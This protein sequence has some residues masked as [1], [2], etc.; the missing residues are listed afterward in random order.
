MHIKKSY[1]VR[2][3]LTIL[4]IFLA[5]NTYSLCSIDP[6][7]HEPVKGDPKGQWII[8]EEN[9]SL[10][11]TDEAYTQ[12][13][14]VSFAYDIECESRWI[15]SIGKNIRESKFG[16]LINI[17]D[18]RKFEMRSTLGLG[19]H[20]FSPIDISV[21]ELIPN[22][23]PY[24]AYLY[25]SFLYD[26]TEDPFN[27]Y[28]KYSH[29]YFNGYLFG[30]TQH[31]IELQLGW[32]GPNAGGK[33]AQS[34]V[35]KLIDA[36]KPMGWSNQLPNEPAFFAE[37]TKRHRIAHLTDEEQVNFDI[38]PSTSLAL[39]TVQDY[40]SIG[41]IARYG[42][43]LS[44]F[45]TDGLSPV[46]QVDDIL[47]E[48]DAICGLKIFV[49]CYAF[50]GAETRFIAHNI[51]LDG[52]LFQNSHSVDKKQVVTDLS[53]GFRLR[54]PWRSLT[55]DYSYIKRSNEFSPV[56]NNASKKSGTHEYGILTFKWASFF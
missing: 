44:G 16:D 45:H 37:Y 1:R 46:A 18:H 20:L 3:F 51:F 5:S 49:E 23:R 9:D 2:G 24:G 53:T 55:L 25:T 27:D 42:K 35:H 34:T 52:S 8:Q 12:G 21:K 38:T 15:N 33:W 48:I 28:G 47:N 19:Q 26:F 7:K 39:G 50:I 4:L 32:I 54:F 6:E 29:T 10:A 56:P 11:T 36:T 17:N 31:S 43:N 22:D 40:A 14:R 30:Q 13:L 41:F